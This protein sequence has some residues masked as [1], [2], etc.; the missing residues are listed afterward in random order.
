MNSGDLSPKIEEHYSDSSWEDA[1]ANHP[2]K[3]C[4]GYREWRFLCLDQKHYSDNFEGGG[5]DNSAKR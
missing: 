5:E 1:G 2:G 4:R 3:G